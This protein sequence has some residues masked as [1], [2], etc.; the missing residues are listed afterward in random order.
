MTLRSAMLAVATS[1]SIV[2]LAGCSAPSG[3]LTLGGGTWLCSDSDTVSAITVG[4][5]ISND[6]TVPVTATATSAGATGAV[7]IQG[8]WIVPATDPT[9]PA[10]LPTFVDGVPP[11]AD[12][13]EWTEREGVEGVQLQ[14]GESAYLVFQLTLQEGQLPEATLSDITVSYDDV[15]RF[16]ESDQFFRLTPEPETCMP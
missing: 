1:V 10:D 9:D 5:P 16:A 3:H 13:I 15:T 11:S 2:A 12:L 8:P 6:G 4:V 14:P 7:D